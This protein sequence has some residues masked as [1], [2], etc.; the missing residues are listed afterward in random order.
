M[1]KML[2]SVCGVDSKGKEINIMPNQ[3]TNI[4]S[5]AEEGRY[6]AAGLAVAVQKKT[7]TPAKAKK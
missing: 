7:K 5:S 2:T 4:F 3:E 1:I 6:I